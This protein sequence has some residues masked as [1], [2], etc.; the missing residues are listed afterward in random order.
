MANPI[1][2]A[3]LDHATDE[4]RLWELTYALSEGRGGKVVEVHPKITI[5]EARP[6]LTE[7]LSEGHVEVY[8]EH[9]SEGSQPLG[10]AAAFAV[11]ND[12][13]NWVPPESDDGR[14]TY[15]VLTTHTG[16]DEYT[17]ERDACES[18]P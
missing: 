6:W 10:L 2:F 11:V 13:A 5:A 12:D 4:A 1:R 14:V 8:E 9:A 15:S 17:N 16:D 18:G 7:L 3:L